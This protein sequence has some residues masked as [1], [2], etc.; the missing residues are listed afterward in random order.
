MSFKIT[1]TITKKCDLKTTLKGVAVQ[2]I[3]F[4]RED[5][6]DYIYPSAIGKNIDLL[7]PFK[8]GDKIELEIEL[9]GSMEQFNNVVIEGA[10]KIK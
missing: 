3:F 10:L 7:N 6:G 9:R 8:Q 5:N 4:K 2:Q 1:G